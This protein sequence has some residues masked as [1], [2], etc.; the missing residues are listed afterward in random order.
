VTFFYS[1]GQKLELRDEGA[2]SVVEVTSFEY[3]PGLNAL[4]GDTVV[5]TGTNFDP[6]KKWVNRVLF[7]DKTVCDVKSVSST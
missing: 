6:V 1:N 7:D 4:G 2:D 5:I 3:Q